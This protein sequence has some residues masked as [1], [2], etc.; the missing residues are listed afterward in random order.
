MP[1]SHTPI[2]I[3]GLPDVAIGLSVIG[4]AGPTVSA[5]CG[6]ANANA[7]QSADTELDVIDELLDVIDEL[8]ELDD[9][10]ELDEDI[11]LLDD[12]LDDDVIDDELDVIDDDVDDSLDVPRLDVSDEDDI[13]LISEKPEKELSSGSPS[14]I[15]NSPVTAYPAASSPAVGIYVASPVF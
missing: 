9:E 11:E 15:M 5:D 10:L 6:V 4:S 7:A 3:A 13:E 2:H 1:F 14:Q 12:E 8:D